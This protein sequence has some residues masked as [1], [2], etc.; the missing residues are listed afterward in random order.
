MLVGEA[1]QS[2]PVGGKVLASRA[3]QFFASA[4]GGRDQRFLFEAF[5]R[6]RDAAQRNIPSGLEIGTP[7]A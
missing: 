7:Q 2:G 3:G 4:D 1:A 5:E 6:R